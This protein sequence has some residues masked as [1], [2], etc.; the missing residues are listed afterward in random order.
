MKKKKTKKR[1]RDSHFRVEMVFHFGQ[2]WIQSLT[3]G[4]I[5]NAI[6]G[7]RSF[8][9]ARIE[10]FNLEKLVRKLKV[11]PLDALKRQEGYPEGSM[12]VVVNCHDNPTDI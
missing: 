1:G 12:I 11:L 2:G 5:S 9:C 10:M 8:I 4:V 3:K 7:S 6:T